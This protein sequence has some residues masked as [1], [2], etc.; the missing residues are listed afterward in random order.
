MI[1]NKTNYN[2]DFYKQIAKQ[3]LVK[4]PVFYLGIIGMC[5]Y[6]YTGIYYLM[7]GYKQI[8]GYICLIFAF[9]LTPIFCF[10]LPYRTN[11]KKY[12]KTMEL[13]HNNDYI[14][15]VKFSNE[16]LN[17]KNS[18]KKSELHNYKEIKSIVVKD[19]LITIKIKGFDP[20]YMDKNSFVDST[21]DDFKNFLTARSNI[22]FKD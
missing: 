14:V 15:E 19:N 6:C 22:K 13:T 10:I 21:Y 1:L 5:L 17:V 8:L 9:V 11:C 18:L 20:I 12:K 4:D 16:S 2:Q 3:K 7:L